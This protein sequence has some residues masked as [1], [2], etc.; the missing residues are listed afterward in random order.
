MLLFNARPEG[1]IF[2]LG[3]NS[4]FCKI[5]RFAGWHAEAR[6]GSRNPFFSS[7][8]CVCWNCNFLTCAAPPLYFSHLFV[9][10]PLLGPKNLQKNSPT[11][12]VNSA[13]SFD[14]YFSSVFCPFFSPKCDILTVSFNLTSCLVTRN[15]YTS[16]VFASRPQKRRRQRAT[17]GDQIP[18]L[19]L[20][21]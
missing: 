7:V 11:R 13:L 21:T 15:H 9:H 8:L 20:S 2:V 17:R 4:L 19:R 5:H 12:G 18:F 16:S 10:S 6:R 1:A 14:P 3:P